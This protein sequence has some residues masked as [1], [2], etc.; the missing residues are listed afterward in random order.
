MMKKEYIKPE[1]LIVKLQHQ[2][3]LM[4]VS[5]LYNEEEFE[6]DEDGFYDEEVLR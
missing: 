1:M 4:Q 6:Y 2:N 3:H 5:G